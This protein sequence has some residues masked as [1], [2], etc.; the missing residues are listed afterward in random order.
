[1][2]SK[3]T[4]ETIKKAKIFA[5]EVAIKNFYKKKKRLNFKKGE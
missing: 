2:Q 5:L 4:H 3:V 1:M